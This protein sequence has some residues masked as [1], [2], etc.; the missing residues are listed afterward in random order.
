MPGT[1]GSHCRRT[2]THPS[3]CLLLPGHRQA[4]K[5]RCCS[6]GCRQRSSSC[7]PASGT[8]RPPTS[9]RRAGGRCLLCSPCGARV[10][11]WRR[12]GRLAPRPASRAARDPTHGCRPWRRHAWRQRPGSSRPWSCRRARAHAEQGCCARRS[13]LSVRV[14]RHNQSAHLH[15]SWPAPTA[16][17]AQGQLRRKQEQ[18][19]RMAAQLTR[20]EAK[21]RAQLHA[22]SPGEACAVGWD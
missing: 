18:L 16:A 20:A 13:A 8:R 11:W 4:A 2:P 22:L 21:Y 10:P 5:R 19:E 3:S 9:S 14:F 12:V 15:R 17:C 1:A 6:E 7:W